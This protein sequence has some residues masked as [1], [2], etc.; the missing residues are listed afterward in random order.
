MSPQLMRLRPSGSPSMERMEAVE[1]E[2]AAKD[3]E[4][5]SRSSSRLEP[6]VVAADDYFVGVRQRL[7][8]V[9]CGLDLADASVIAEVACMDEQIAVRDVVPF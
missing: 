8:P 9:D 6:V 3:E 5:A 1:E 2:T 4:E 7:E